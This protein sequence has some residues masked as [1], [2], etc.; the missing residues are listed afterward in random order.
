MFGVN[1]YSPYCYAQPYGGQNFSGS[2]NNQ[3]FA[4]TYQNGMQFS[5]PQQ[6]PQTSG[7]D[8]MQVQ[9]IKQVAQP[10]PLSVDSTGEFLSLVDG[11]CSTAVWAI[12]DDLMDTIRVTAPRV[13]DSIVRKI[14]EI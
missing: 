11:K 13:Y 7:P 1:P 4:Q 12:M 2:Q 8:W 6:P 5:P 3:N 14:K 10:T 9:E